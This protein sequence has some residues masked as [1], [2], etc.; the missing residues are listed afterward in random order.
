[1]FFRVEGGLERACFLAWRG[2]KLALVATPE[3]GVSLEVP[4][5]PG[6][7]GM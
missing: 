1:V 6:P 3:A 5:E 7:L 2:G 4:H